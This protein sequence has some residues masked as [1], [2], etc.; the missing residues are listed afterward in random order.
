MKL[1]SSRRWIV[2]AA[3]I[4]MQAV[5]GGVYA[6]SVFVPPLTEEYG[7][8]RAQC[9]SIFGVTIA[10]FTLS[11]IP[12]GR[13]L[14]RRG[15]RLTASIGASLF[16]LGYVLASFSEGSYTMLL[17]SLG[18]I[19]GAGIGF[20]YVCP[21]TLTMRWFPRTKG[22][23]TG[24]AV[25][26]F[27]GGAILL[28]LLA[29]Y[30]LYAD[31]LR[32]EVLEVFRFVGFFMG[33]AALISATFLR[34]PVSTG[35][36]RAAA[37]VLPRTTAYL[38]STTFWLMC[39]GMF[40]GTFAGL[41]TVANLKPI[42][43]DLGLDDHL[44]TV[45]V[46]L[47]AVGNVVGRIVWGHIHDRLGSGTT[48]V[49]SLAFLC[50]AMISLLLRGPAWAT[51]SSTVAV[52]VGF[53]ACFIVY[54]SAMVDAFGVKMFPRLYPLCFLAYGLAGLTGPALGGWLA[55]TTASYG[56]AVVVSATIVLTALVLIRCTP[57]Q[58]ARVQMEENCQ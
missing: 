20:G 30:L 14:Q 40:A 22:L 43:V 25:A 50:S 19:S 24:A 48:I 10:V 17:V 8:T 12:A 26:A 35:G 47:F 46:T 51:L 56:I 29:E 53:G 18:V 37:E 42:A 15:P 5:F 38:R 2:L 57:S 16:V 28:S 6:W 32:Y 21:L 11:M 52:G 27:G 41:L 49:L 34:E 4:V 39:L 7:L 44:A 3:S 13:L 31:G 45:S 54:A 33:G 36:D 9:G 58:R 23:A 55:D 1:V